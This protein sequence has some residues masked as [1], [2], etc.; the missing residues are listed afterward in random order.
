MS[1]GPG[2]LAWYNTLLYSRLLFCYLELSQHIHTSTLHVIVDSPFINCCIE[3]GRSFPL[4]PQSHPIPSQSLPLSVS[5]LHSHTRSLAYASLSLH[6]NSTPLPGQ[7][8]TLL[9]PL[10]PLTQLSLLCS[11]LS[12]APYALH[13]VPRFLSWPAPQ[14][15]TRR[16]LSDF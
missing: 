11:A 5:P 12:S 2:M 3:G 6:S 1:Q 13:F 9:L 7:D 8:R 4:L 14:T 10:P 15:H 16:W